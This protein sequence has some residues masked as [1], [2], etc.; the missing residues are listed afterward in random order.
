MPPDYGTR[1][2]AASFF[3]LKSSQIFLCFSQQGIDFSHGEGEELS[4]DLVQFFKRGFEARQKLFYKP[5][6]F[7]TCGRMQSDAP[8]EMREL[9]R[10]PV[11]F[12]RSGAAGGAVLNIRQPLQPFRGARPS[13]ERIYRF[14]CNG[15]LF[16]CI[17]AY[18]CAGF[19]CSA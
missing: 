11:V 10:Q 19:Q 2:D 6:F 1:F 17:C 5:A 15:F 14:P 4:A 9:L 8:S 13:I 3:I 7:F 16:P 12:D 18:S